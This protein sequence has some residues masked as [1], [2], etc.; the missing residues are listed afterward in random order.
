M[1]FFYRVEFAV[2]S[3]GGFLLFVS[4]MLASINALCRY[5]LNYSMSFADEI[6]I[7][8]IVISVFLMQCRLEERGE[9]LS[10]NVLEP[11]LN[12]SALGRNLMFWARAVVIITI[13][14]LMTK[15]GIGVI[16]LNYEI[17]TVT[18]VL[19]FPMW[20]VYAAYTLGMALI[21]LAW[22]FIFYGKLTGRTN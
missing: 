22:V 16:I 19:M 11:F 5:L 17:R 18:A 15:V 8:G 12:K 1:N 6:S 3:I 10:V 13:W 4:T 21:L 2:S 7:F 20:I 9:Q 14:I